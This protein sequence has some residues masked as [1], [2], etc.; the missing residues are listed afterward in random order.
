MKGR[1]YQSAGGTV[2]NEHRC[3]I[4][5]NQ[6]RNRKVLEGLQRKMI[7]VFEETHPFAQ[8][9]PAGLSLEQQLS[10]YC[11]PPDFNP[12]IEAK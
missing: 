2:I 3:R 7:D 4:T 12:D 11:E 5:S 8:N 6:L 9:I 10:F 1:G